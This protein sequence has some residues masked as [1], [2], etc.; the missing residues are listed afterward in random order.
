M[1][2]KCI[3]EW[4]YN[5]FSNL[6]YSL[7]RVNCYTPVNRRV[8][9][10]QGAEFKEWTNCYPIVESTMAAE[11]GSPPSCFNSVYN[12]PLEIIIDVGNCYEDITGNVNFRW[13]GNF[14]D[15]NGVYVLH[16][17]GN[18]TLPL[19]PLS[20]RDCIKYILNPA[21]VFI[22]YS[23][24]SVTPDAFIDCSEYCDCCNCCMV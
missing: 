5:W 21:N 18:A 14:L 20:S 23:Y 24:F 22:G 16:S 19:S 6:F 17:F 15:T 13:F 12:S 9:L 2:K 8:V 11:N 1:S 3:V 10:A 7:V 4:D